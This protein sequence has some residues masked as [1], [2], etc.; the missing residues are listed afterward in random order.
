MLLLAPRVVPV[1]PATLLALVLSIAAAALFDLDDHGVAL[2]G[3]IPDA[4]PDPAIP[5]VDADD[6]VS[7][8]APAIGV[9]IV[10]AEAVGVARALATEHGYR[11]DAN[12]DLVGLGAANLLAGLSSGFVQSGG[13]SQTAAADGAGGRSQ[14]AALSAAGLILLTGAFL[15]PL[16]EDL[17]QATL[18]AIVVVAVAGFFRVRRAAALP[19]DPAERRRLGRPGARRSAGA[20]RPG[21]PRDHGRAHADLR[22]PAT[23]PAVGRAARARSGNRCLGAR[24]A[25]SR[26]GA[27]GRRARRAQRRPALLRQHR[28][29]QAAHPE[30]GRRANRVPPR[31]SWISRE[32]FEVDVQTAD[33]LAELIDE[34]E[35]EGIELRL[36]EV[37][38]PALDVLRRAGV[39]ERVRIDATLD[40]AVR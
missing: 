8:I 9:L 10:S 5:D 19:A 24:R 28:P 21:G 11:V 2:I 30:P 1:L 27:P 31:W 36:A 15:A 18:A 26:L 20:R 35:K 25:T 7:L 29:D 22:D 34:L 33:T 6:V 12:R 39:A 3:D 37:R 40:E 4:L 32:T 38:A 14:F 17:P 13:A 16:F 23:L